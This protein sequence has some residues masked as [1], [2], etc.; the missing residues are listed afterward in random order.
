M[1]CTKC[2]APNR[3]GAKFCVG[4]GEPI[5]S[6]GVSY[7]A[8]SPAPA[9]PAGG[10]GNYNPTELQTAGSGP[11][12]FQMGGAAPTAL[13]TVHSRAGGAQGP[14]GAAGGTIIAEDDVRPLA[15]W[16]VVLRSNDVPVYRDVPIFMGQN[17]LGRD[18][19]LGQQSIPDRL[20]SRDHAIA[21]AMDGPG[22]RQVQLSNLS[23]KNGT[24]VNRAKI[25]TT[26][27]NGGDMVRMGKTTMVYVPYP[28]GSLGA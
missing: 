15:G 20:V 10:G 18:A 22:G 14:P 9:P 27:L 12:G 28:E 1:Q 24:L 17:R 11:G 16:L 19:G 23:D 6:A 21:V 5:M 26:V 13:E 3:D 7:G 25:Q 8:Q 2:R 4:C